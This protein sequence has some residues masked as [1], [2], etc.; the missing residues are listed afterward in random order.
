[1]G[2]FL[3]VQYS[4]GLFQWENLKH[5][6]FKTQAIRRYEIYLLHCYVSDK[7]LW[8]EM[9][10]KVREGASNATVSSYVIPEC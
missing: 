7:I 3:K 8:K 5:A 2:Q 9:S 10:L 1:M 6:V 4:V